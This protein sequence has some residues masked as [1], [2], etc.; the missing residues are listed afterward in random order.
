MYSAMPRVAIHPSAAIADLL[1]RQRNRLG[2]SLREAETRS[3]SLGDPIPFSTLARVEQG[4]VDPGVRRLHSLLRM[5]GLPVEF[6]A[7]VLDLE[8]MADERP[9]PA[10]PEVLGRRGVEYIKAGDLRKG[11]AHLFALRTGE[12]QSK[13][14]RSARQKAL[15]AMA[16]AAGGLGRYE[17][18]RHIVEGLLREPPEPD[19]ISR[20]L[21]QAAVCWRHLGSAEACLAFL[22]RAEE[23]TEG[24]AGSQERAFVLHEKAQALLDL[25]DLKGAEGALRAALR[26]YRRAKDAYGECRAMGVRAEIRLAAGQWAEALRVARRGRAHAERH[27]FRRV[28]VLRLLDEGRALAGSGDTEAAIDLFRE[29]L[30]GAIR[31]GDDVARFYAHYH[32]WKAH[33]RAGDPSRAAVELEEAAYYGKLL[34]DVSPEV[35]EVRSAGRPPARRRRRT[36]SR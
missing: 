23:R 26:C 3:A 36:P 24:P 2:L 27:G 33:E 21:V 17:L 14:D 16:V 5:Y 29:A 35:R 18:S 32:L 7:D 1:R 4:K 6:A 28:R 12:E 11:L 9:A 13:A 22:L 25:S 20:C 15:L 31:I 19:L 30:S 34:D 8:A 10:P